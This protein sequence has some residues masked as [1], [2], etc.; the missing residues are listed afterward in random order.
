MSWIGGEII[1]NNLG[2]K[3]IQKAYDIIRSDVRHNADLEEFPNMGNSLL[4]IKHICKNKIF[5]DRDSA[6]EYIDEI[7]SNWYRKY[8]PCV[9]FY[10]TSKAVR[11]KKIIG[12]ETR[13][14][15]E[16]EKMNDYKA[17]HQIIN[18]KAK[19]VTCSKCGSKINKIYI[20]DD[21][22]PLCNHN[23]Q[24]KTT[25]DTIERYTKKIEELKKAIKDE[26]IKNKKK[27]PVKYVLVFTE[28]CG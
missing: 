5:N 10:D 19:L 18:Y 16:K 7:S 20:K 13:L 17:A 2:K 4:S 15:K 9:A 24:S 8:Q 22:C 25:K 1:L 6:V 21:R 12:L 28:Y 26:K 11:S 27:L 14:Q 3:E 23:L